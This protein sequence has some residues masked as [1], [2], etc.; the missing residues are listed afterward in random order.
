ES[1]IPCST[2]GTP[3][4][5]RTANTANNRGR[6]F[7]SCPSQ[8]CNFFVWEDSLGD[9]AGGRSVPRANGSRSASNPGRRGGRGRG[10]QG[11]GH[12]PDMMFVSA[13]GDP[14]SGR[15]CF[16]CGDPSHF[17]NACPT[18]GA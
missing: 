16:A 8:E 17:A 14:I 4:V 15:R 6:K 5:L 2:C 18:R 12:G 3:C 13:T 10:G 11:R 7:Y 1:S 9:D